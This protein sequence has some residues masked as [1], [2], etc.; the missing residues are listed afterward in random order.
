MKSETFLKVIVILSMITLILILGITA[1][2]YLSGEYNQKIISLHRIAGTLIF[3]ILPIHIYLRREK[4][5][6][7]LKEF[8][9]L[10]MRGRLKQSCTNHALLKTFKQRSLL[11]L[12][13]GLHI[14]IDEV[15]DFLDQKDIFVLNIKDPMEK[16][17]NDNSNDPLKI[18]VMIIENHLHSALA[19][20]QI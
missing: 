17:A 5:K 11:E 12:C 14:E 19:L 7:L 13:D 3:T 4:L 16:I 2:I 20:D 6:K 1:L 9:S 15:I 10:L 18:F 8:F